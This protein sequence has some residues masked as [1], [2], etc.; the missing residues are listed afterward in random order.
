MLKFIE[1]IDRKTHDEFIQTSPYCSLLQSS[2]WA[3]IKDNWNH[4]IV[5][6][7]KDDELVASALVLIK[8]LPLHMSMMYIPRGPV[9]D[10]NDVELIRF[11]FDN[12]KQW[13]KKYHTL[14]IKLDPNIHVK[15]YK[16]EEVME[17][18]YD[19]TYQII[20]NLKQGNLIH[21]GFTTY[22]EESIQP[23]FQANVY[24]CDNFEES[25]PRHTK[26]LVKDALKHHVQ[27]EK[28]DISALNQFAEV[29]KKTENRKNVSLRNY[30][31]FDK[32]MKIYG[33]DAYLFLAKVNIEKTLND[34]Y[35]QQEDNSKDLASLKQNSPKKERRLLDI[36]ASLEKS[37]AEFESFN[38]EYQGDTVIAGILSVKFGN[39]MEM[40]YA[41]MDEHFKKFMPQYYLYIENMKYGFDHGCDY[42]NMGGIEGDLNDG[43]TQF[44]SNFNPMINEY[45]GE[46]DLPVNGLLY[47]LSKKAYT[48]RKKRNL[49]K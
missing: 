30:E 47:H 43:L 7:K 38:D 21:Q 8:P 11:F 49:K 6:V 19:G 18:Y 44:K 48:F 23:R 20:D 33:D 16:L 40:L 3:C 1:H 9:M 42:A 46:F 2:K 45:I 22:M 27:V 10:F 17:N 14:F 15:D 41:G 29:V 12:L 32:L 31:Y 34:L 24:K 35:Q 5:G 13:A 37:I 28:A 39:T 26:R 36:K 25:L 4:E